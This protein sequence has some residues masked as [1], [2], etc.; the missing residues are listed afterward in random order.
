M[1]VFM[2]TNLSL[3][4]LRPSLDWYG[5]YSVQI[6][7]III[8]KP[9]EYYA[10]LCKDEVVYPTMLRLGVA[11]LLWTGRGQHAKYL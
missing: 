7:N 4:L 9:I 11:N 1:Q 6:A 8:G 10:L 3:H 2:K 5:D